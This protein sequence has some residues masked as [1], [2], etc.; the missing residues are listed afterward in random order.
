MGF[1]R[2]L[3]RLRMEEKLTQ[4]ALGTAFHISRTTISNYETGKQEPSLKMLVELAAFFDVSVD[5]L[6]AE[7]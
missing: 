6:L 1:S 7:D 5:Q 4:Q 3:R 2:N